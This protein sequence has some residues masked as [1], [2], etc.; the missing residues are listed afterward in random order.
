MS[1]NKLLIVV[2]D[3]IWQTKL[4]SADVQQEARK[5]GLLVGFAKFGQSILKQGRDVNLEVTAS[6]PERVTIVV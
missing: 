5:V 1:G 6:R 3:K 2:L 4:I